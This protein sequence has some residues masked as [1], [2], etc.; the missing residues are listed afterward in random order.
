MKKPLI[1]VVDDTEASRYLC[2]RV[3]RAA[4]MEVI[5]AGT[6]EEALR[7]AEERKPEL[8]VLDIKLPDMSGLEVCR[9]IRAGRSGQRVAILHVSSTYV[10]PEAEIES[11]E[12][13]ADIYLAQPV[14]PRELVSVVKALIRMR[15]LDEER[16]A[17][18]RLGQ[19]ALAEAQQVARIKDE[20]L[21]TL[22][23]EL[24]TPIGVLSN[25]LNVMR[26]GPATPEELAQGLEVMERNARWM[27]KLIN[28]LLDVSGIISGKVALER[29]PSRIETI[30]RPAVESIRPAAVAKGI[31]ITTDLDP[32]PGPVSV[33]P[34]R[35]QQVLANLLSN[36]IKFTGQ[37]GRIEVR[38]RQ[39]GM[40]IQITVADTGEGIAPGMLSSIFERFRQADSSITRRHGGLGLGLAIVRHIVELHGGAVSAHSDGPGKGSRFTVTLPY[41]PPTIQRGTAAAAVAELPPRGSRLKGLRILAVDDDRD[42]RDVL[43]KL[44]EREKAEV[45]TAGS[46]RDAVQ[47]VES[48]QPDILLLDL[49]M[50]GES[51][52]ELLARLRQMGHRAPAV[53]MTGYARE[54]DA[55]RARYAGFQAHLAKPFH[56][57]DLCRQ[58][59]ALVPPPS[60]QVPERSREGGK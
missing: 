11:Q 44:L 22:S 49:G 14:E 53:A 25:W 51:G 8:L 30:I 17:V 46:A 36:A 50:P 56:M 29:E 19:A 21:A 41:F 15:E 54:E 24:R 12:S 13:G 40:Q 6:G 39:A 38:C 48:W 35:M 1:L 45:R 34:N 32:L 20:F 55:A 43:G 60:R 58:I 27:T 47:S 57:D 59:A 26:Q 33:D 18:L 7:L 52:Y 23:H 28:D 42:A 9:R 31:A 10:T 2:A 5:E 3:L 16:E 4:R 37:G